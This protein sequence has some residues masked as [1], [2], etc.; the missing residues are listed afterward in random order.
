M[1]QGISVIIITRNRH[2]DLATCLQSLA[3]QTR[4]PDEVIVVDNGPS[5]KTK[6][7]CKIATTFLPIVYLQELRVGIPYARNTGIK[8]SRYTLTAFIDDDCVAQPDWLSKMH[9][10]FGDKS[11]DAVIGFAKCF[12]QNPIP[13]VEQAFYERNLSLDELISKN[14]VVKNGKVFDF[15]NVAVRTSILNNMST[16]FST[17]APF[18]DVGDE[19][20]EFGLRLFTCCERVL[21][22]RQMIVYHKNSKTFGRLMVRNFYNGVSNALLSKLNKDTLIKRRP[23]NLVKLLIAIKRN[24]ELLPTI[25][26]KIHFFLLCILFPVPYRAGKT[27]I[28]LRELTNQPYQIPSRK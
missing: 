23:S 28:A 17:L 22:S 2:N 12:H 15:K 20:I 24:A 11:V 27:F 19:D 3:K 25:Y 13:L 5:I 26:E 10:I 7:V 18:G 21:F 1:N 6:A 14:N 16:L 9:T 8:A 4:H